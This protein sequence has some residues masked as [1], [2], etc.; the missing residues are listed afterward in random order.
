MQESQRQPKARGRR[1][2][3]W[4]AYFGGRA[5]FLEKQWTIDVLIRNACASG[6]KLVVS[7]ADFVP[8]EFTLKVQK[9]QSEYRAISRWR[10]GGEIGVEFI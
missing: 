6:A 1:R 7:A 2:Q 8:N 9:D 5:C 3:R 4:P 10:R